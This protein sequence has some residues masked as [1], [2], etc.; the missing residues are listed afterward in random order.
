MIKLRPH[1]ILCN[2]C[3]IGSGYSTAFIDNF[4]KI[5]QEILSNPTQ[6]FII[7]NSLDDICTPCPSNQRTQCKEQNKVMNLDKLHSQ[8]LQITNKRTITWN[9]CVAKIQTN[10][11]ENTFHDICNSCEWYKLGICYNKLFKS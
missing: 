11:N 6:E 7:D 3:F 1:H 10:I 5:N 8:A 9:E 4:K 2:Y